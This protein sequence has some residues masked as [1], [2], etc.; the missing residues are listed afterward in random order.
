MLWDSPLISDEGIRIG[1]PV[2]NIARNTAM[3]FSVYGM[4]EGQ[5]P[6]FFIDRKGFFSLFFCGGKAHS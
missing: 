2:N 6:A 1:S 5:N 4:A 3:V